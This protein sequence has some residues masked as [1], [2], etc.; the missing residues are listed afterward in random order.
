MINDNHLEELAKKL[1]EVLPD[2]IQSL[3][4]EMQKKF[5]DV[6]QIAFSKLDLVT[7]DEFDVQLKVLA[8]TREKVEELEDKLSRVC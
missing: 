1:L 6:L 3:N 2:N 7:R 8:R 5:H 4:S